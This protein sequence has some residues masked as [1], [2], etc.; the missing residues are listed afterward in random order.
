MQDLLYLA[1]ED[2]IIEGNPIPATVDGLP[3]L[4]I[5]RVDGKIFVTDNLCTHGNALLSDGFQ[6]GGIIEC[7]FHGGAFDIS[8]GAPSRFPCQ[9]ALKTYT[10]I[11][12]EGYVCLS[13]NELAA[14]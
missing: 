11:L 9:T 1:K 13:R 12:S 8:T 4:V 2:D 10:P 14:P 3:P 7:P 5:F 6:D